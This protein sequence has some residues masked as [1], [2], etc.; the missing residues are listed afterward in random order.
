M[1][2]KAA[3]RLGRHQITTTIPIATDHRMCGIRVPGKVSKA[4]IFYVYFLKSRFNPGVWKI[5][6]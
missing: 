2:L 3:E 6:G 5:L 4:I 1:L